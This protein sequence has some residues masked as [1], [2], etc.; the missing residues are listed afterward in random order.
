VP[1]FNTET[2]LPQRTVNNQE[3]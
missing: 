1:A 2:I 3:N